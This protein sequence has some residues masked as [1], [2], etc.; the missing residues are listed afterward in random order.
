CE[1]AKPATATAGGALAGIAI[2]NCEPGSDVAKVAN[3][4]ASA[5]GSA[6]APGATEP[7]AVAAGLQ[8]GRPG[9]QERAEGANEAG[10][11][12]SEQ[13]ELTLMGVSSAIAL[14]GIGL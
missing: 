1:A 10:K 6:P 4:T 13:L 7:A 3:V 5:V 2:A 9:L 8:S 12:G 14:L 11:H